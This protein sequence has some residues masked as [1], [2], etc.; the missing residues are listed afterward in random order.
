MTKL[1]E[2]TLTGAYGRDYTS[3]AD[4]VADFEDGYDFRLHTP[5]G[6][7]YCSCRDFAEGA[8]IKLRY[9]KRQ[10]VC[11]YIKDWNKSPDEVKGV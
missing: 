5:Q 6:S 2:G 9:C 8:T 10:Y 11:I 3:S 1:T 7:T 4:I